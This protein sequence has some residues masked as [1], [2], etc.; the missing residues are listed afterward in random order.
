MSDAHGRG[1][2]RISRR[3]VWTVRRRTLTILLLG[4]DHA[5]LMPPN[6]T[7]NCFTSGL[8]NERGERGLVAA[9]S[10]RAW[11][12]KRLLVKLEEYRQK[13]HFKT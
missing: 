6:P 3:V 4:C 9:P 10:Y 2:L 13:I 12:L 7:T 5:V 11:M 1:F 8:R